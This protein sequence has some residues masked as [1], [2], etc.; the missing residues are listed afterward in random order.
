MERFRPRHIIGYRKRLLRLTAWLAIGAATPFACANPIIDPSAPNGISLYGVASIP[1][2]TGAN[3][4]GYFLE[5]MAVSGNNL[6]VSVGSAV[7]NLTQTV[8]SMPLIRTDGHITGLGSATE[9]A[10]VATGTDQGNPLGGGLV[11]F[12][13]GLLY[14]TATSSNFGQYTG[15]STLTNIQSQVPSVGGMNYIPAGQIGAGQLK[16]DS[17]TNGS[18][19]TLNLTGSPGA[20]TFQSVTASNIN[21]PALSFAYLIPDATF[22]NPSVVLGNGSNINVYGLDGNG[23]PCNTNSCAP[24]IHLVDA[25]NSPIGFGVVRDPLTGDI[26]FDTGNNQLWVISDSIEPAPEPGAIALALGGI[27]LLA[28][29]ARHRR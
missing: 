18:W 29:R 9:F 16:V 10:T 20:Y 15:S 26:L 24:V 22:L 7:N 8:W 27:A 25:V 2:F 1:D 23:N 6:L 21:V 28:A 5:G 14:T 3:P 17:T 11:T 12:D 19:Y 13:G 4:F